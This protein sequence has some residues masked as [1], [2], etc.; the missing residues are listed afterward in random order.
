MPQ[1]DLVPHDLTPPPGT[2][3]QGSQVHM[4]PFPTA[5]RRLSHGGSRR[6]H[7]P[8]EPSNGRRSRRP[9]RRRRD[10]KARR[11]PRRSREPQSQEHAQTT[12]NH[13]TPQQPE[14]PAPENQEAGSAD[15]TSPD[16]RGSQ[17][18][19]SVRRNSHTHS[20]NSKESQVSLPIR[21]KS[22][23]T[24]SESTVANPSRG[25]PSH[26]ISRSIP[27]TG[28]TSDA[29]DNAKAQQTNS[30]EPRQDIDDT[31]PMPIRISLADG[32]TLTMDEYRA[33][34]EKRAGKKLAP[35]L[36]S[37]AKEAPPRHF[38]STP[39]TAQPPSSKTMSAMDLLR[40][41]GGS[42]N[43][44]TTGT[45]L[46]PNVR[47]TS[48]KVH[49]AA[50]SFLDSVEREAAREIPPRA[51]NLCEESC[52]AKAAT[53][54]EDSPTNRTAFEEDYRR[55]AHVRALQ[56]EVDASFNSS[57]HQINA[58]ED[59]RHINIRTENACGD[60]SQKAGNEA[61]SQAS[62][63]SFYAIICR[64]RDRWHSRI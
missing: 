42:S 12:P 16:P 17:D 34:K 61:N 47:R 36:A 37:S 46:R 63:P 55:Q 49:A 6:H 9:E 8:R 33:I 14:M 3:R 45:Q 30:S 31:K 19:L 52:R 43:V 57:V 54:D 39:R 13:P 15:H 40:E 56:S 32:R 7:E 24:P 64:R 38:A 35:S 62:G 59:N 58:C 41:H 51:R 50:K 25:G 22:R 20:S 60:N 53:R 26:P 10:S 23:I 44:N 28:E 11:R 2:P 4:D 29:E 18:L 27:I 48:L 21:P 5:G 1:H